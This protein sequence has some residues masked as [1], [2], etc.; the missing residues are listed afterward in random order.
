MSRIS[1]VT[2]LCTA[3]IGSVTPHADAQ[4]S[5]ATDWHLV[6]IPETWRHVPKG[7]LAPLDGYSWYRATVRIPIEWNG[8]PLKLFMESLDDARSAWLNGKLVGVSGTFPPQFRSGLGE[9]A[10][11]DVDPQAIRYGEFNTFAIRVYQNDPR[12]NFSVAPPII[13]NEQ[14]MEGI[15]LEGQWQ[16]QPGDV[17]NAAT[18]VLT[19][20]G[21]KDKDS[22]NPGEA[23]ALAVYQKIDDI[24]NVDRYVS[25][26][27]GDTVPLSPQKALTKFD[28]SEDLDIELV[29]GDPEIAQPLF[30][31]WDGRGRLWVM[32]YRQYPVPAG[33]KMVSRD[34]FLRSVYDKV[35]PPP[36]NHFPGA[37]RITIHEDSNGDGV[38]DVH[39]TF[40]D[41]LS[42][43]SSFA[44]GRGGV[45]VTN[46]P[47]LLFY[48]DRNGDDIPD[49]D[50]DVLLE[51]FGIEDSH[52]VINSL[53]FGPDGW[54][55]GAQ[56][57]TVTAAV[58]KPGSKEPPVRTVGQQI[59]RYHPEDQRFE[60]F[61]E[62]GGNTFGCEIDSQGRVY[63]GHNGGDTR[64]FHY[65]QGGYYRKGFGKHG[66]LSNPFAFGY[67]EDM[68]HASVPRFTH[69]FVIYED[70]VLPKRLHGKLF[71]IEPLQGRVVVSDVRPDS[72]SFQTEDIDRPLMSADSWFR[73]VDIKTGPDGFVYIA[74]F[75]EQ[76]IDHSSHYAGRID[77]TSGRIYRLVPK[78]R[79]IENSESPDLKSMSSRALVK[80]LA[81]PIRWRRQ[82]AQRILADRHDS[83]L[84]P[85]LTE[86]LDA[87]AGQLALEYLWAL[88]G[89]GGLTDDISMKLLNH[90]EP[91]VRTWTVR[92]TCDRV[93]VA[94]GVATALAD[95]AA[96]EA[97]VRVRKQLASSARRL[98]ADQALPIIQQ[99]LNYDEDAGD[100]HQPLLLWW[101]IEA[102]MASADVNSLLDGV[103]P[104][105]ASWHLDLV[106]MHLLQRLMKRYAMAGTRADLLAAATL[107]NKA[108]DAVSAELLLKGFEE[109]FQGR[110]M[111]ELPTELVKAITA[112]GG[113]SLTLKV[114][115]KQPAAITEAMRLIRDPKASLNERIQLT[116]A[117]GSARSVPVGQFL[118][119]TVATEKDSRLISAALTALQDW[120]D[121]QV[122]DVVV[123]H[124]AA[125]PEE[126]RL[127]A[128]SLLASRVNWATTLL[129]AVEDGSVDAK[130][131]SDQTLRRM[132]LHND[133]EIRKRIIGRWGEIAGATTAAMTAEADRV[134]TLL[135][136]GSGNPKKGKLQYRALCGRC[137]TLFAEGGQIGPDLTPFA[138]G[139]LERMLVNVI[140]P[141]LEIR[142]GF[143]NHVLVTTDGRVLTG[144]VADRD[145]QVVVIRGVDGR[146]VI[147]PMDQI[148]ELRA[149]P[150]S[151]MPEGTLKPLT[152]QQIRDLFAYIRSSQPVN[153]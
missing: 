138:R 131:V 99:L 94:P 16:Y 117:L 1:F 37:D 40:V 109:A 145:A 41:G 67:F 111:S 83:S 44:I 54:L 144:F 12:P 9:A 139:N 116:V 42:L 22:V 65:V 122:A 13:V 50:P 55:Y 140:N 93:R 69:N 91:S 132:L 23:T 86:M 33:L 95:L 68:K 106:K 137:H 79:S 129:Q 148:D 110:P 64:G 61:A 108:P 107:L 100:I 7:E 141:S 38:P 60:V 134:K 62:G 17:S 125:M 82:T 18:A 76:R 120:D 19:D 71:G 102:Q 98:P 96:D 87:A 101:A 90:S 73:P 5:K 149:V 25:R 52:S 6:P 29:V 121:Q 4:E 66:A 3:I 49:S 57:S 147:V 10:A 8:Q 126:S 72:S 2:L 146:N 133:Q 150:Q 97:Y 80:V 105:T 88:H 84:I 153:Y 36:P 112:T 32:E 56:G 48:P 35:P 46:P 24:D 27:I 59:W 85:A 14:A 58:R 152:D 26:R 103:L 70:D 45:Y 128:E 43:A 136:S 39:K 75:Y 77:R 89:S 21:I 30:M 31:T 92:L 130:L 135:S 124:F 74:D 118:R 127:V 11:H 113:G 104:E 34:T 63:S 20:F 142:E 151:V 47:Y 143:E 53:R 15:R 81:G 51:G 28:V 114:L 115:Q 119:E 123:A 78:K